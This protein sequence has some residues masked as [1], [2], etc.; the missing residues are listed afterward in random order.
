ML[1]FCG[2][3]SR[4][5][6]SL[7]TDFTEGRIS[8]QLIKF[9]IPLLLANF[10][11]I[12]YNL[13]D[14]VIVGRFVGTT[15]LDAV[16]VGGDIT[17]FLTIFIIGFA[18][19]AQIIIAQYIGAGKKDV[20]GRFI[21]TFTVFMLIAAAVLTAVCLVFRRQLLF[22]M[23]TPD[24]AMGQAMSYSLITISGLVFIYGYNAVSAVVRGFGDSRHPFIFVV[25]AA[26]LNIVLDLVF[27]AGLGTDA[28]GAALA[29]VISQAV[30]FL[31]AVVFLVI[32][33]ERLGFQIRKSDFVIDRE[34]LEL[35]VKLGIPMALKGASLGFT[36]LFT[37]SW[38]NSYGEVVMAVT[39]IGFKLNTIGLLVSN[40]ISN[41]GSSM[42]GQNIG[43]AKYDRVF[44]IMLSVWLMN[45]VILSGAAVA[46]CSF[47]MQIYSIFTNDERVMITGLEYMPVILLYLG[48]SVARS[49]SNALVN[50]TGNAKVN[51]AVALLDAFILRI[52]LGLWLGLGLGW[53]YKGFWYGSALAS[54]AP[55]FI[56]VIFY[57]SGTWKTRRYVVREEQE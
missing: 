26:G 8:R 34:Q 37:N 17:D 46:F 2:M 1:Q 54:Y 31:G 55:F 52:G 9:A 38:V 53:G 49:G 57:I 27:V 7:I 32:R 40:S 16:A 4:V 29:T 36:K 15:G 21:G 41:A 23:S 51:F 50:G 48:S 18:N 44:R 14:M 5:P 47:P 43:A 6:D 12:L 42:V 45:I 13:T 33:R 24:A 3:R 25:V 19:A 35:L 22:W 20:V 11:Q 56:G 30:S 10:V 28:W 39:G